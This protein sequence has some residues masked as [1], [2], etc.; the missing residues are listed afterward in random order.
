MKAIPETDGRCPHCGGSVAPLN[1]YEPREW[2][3][4]SPI[5]ECGKCGKKYLDRRYHEMEIEGL[6]NAEMSP[7]RDVVGIVVG[8]AVILLSVGV[9]WFTSMVM[10]FYSLKLYYLRYIGALFLVVFTAD[11]IMLKTGIK[12]KNM[13]KKRQESA[14]RLENKEYARELA[15]LGYNVPDKYM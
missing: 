9:V 10:G 8:V 13:E 2:K 6:P 5:R 4:G 7:K 15:E 14:K 12:A 3:I 1:S 11:L